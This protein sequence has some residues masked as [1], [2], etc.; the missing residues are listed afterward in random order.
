MDTLIARLMKSAKRLGVS[1]HD[2]AYL[3]AELAL[4]EAVAAGYEPD[5]AFDIARSELMSA[6][7]DSER[8]DLAHA[9]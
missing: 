4:V 8:N 3:H 2:D 6:L 9:A 7:P 5:I 1:R